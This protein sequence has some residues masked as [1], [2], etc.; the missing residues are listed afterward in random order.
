MPPSKRQAGS[1]AFHPRCVRMCP[2]LA[3]TGPLWGFTGLNQGIRTVCVP[4]VSQ[5]IIF[6]YTS[7]ETNI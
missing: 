7:I 1:I 5:T 4:S 6:K 3:L 2:P